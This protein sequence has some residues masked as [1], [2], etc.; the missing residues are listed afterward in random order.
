[1]H[2]TQQ[3]P[4]FLSSLPEG[5][6]GTH[7]TLVLMRALVKKFRRNP[8][9][10]DLA[11]SLV[12]QLRPRDWTGEIRAL[13]EY[14]R[15]RIRYTKDVRHVETLQIPTVTMELEAGDCDDKS[16]LL[17]TLL[18]SIG[19]PSR[20]VAVGY[21]SPN[22]YSHVYVEAKVGSAWIPLDST[23]DQPFGWTPRPALARMVL[24]N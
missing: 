14:V 17:A 11:I 5:A 16:I 12:S 20:F 21:Q 3:R 1:M 19:H 4:S 22:K 6:Q 7:A 9:M 23:V 13:F 2:L 18:E 24:F 10:R 8:T 15:D